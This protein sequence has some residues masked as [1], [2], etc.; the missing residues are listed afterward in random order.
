VASGVG[1]EVQNSVPQKKKK[2]KKQSNS[3][4]QTE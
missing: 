2:K 1:P 4:T 3:V